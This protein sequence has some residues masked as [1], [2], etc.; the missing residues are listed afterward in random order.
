MTLKELNNSNTNNNNSIFPKS[1]QRYEEDGSVL[2]CPKCI[3]FFRKDE[4]EI[5]ETKSQNMSYPICPVCK[6]KH[7]MRQTPR[8]KRNFRQRTEYKRI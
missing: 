8:N 5:Y 4:C 7:P 3:K 6:I 1:P 2:K